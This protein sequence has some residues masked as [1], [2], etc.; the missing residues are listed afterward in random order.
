MS[1]GSS[2]IAN[3][4]QEIC[5]NVS[6]WNSHIKHFK[7]TP[8]VAKVFMNVLKTVCHFFAKTHCSMLSTGLSWDYFFYTLVLHWRS[9]DCLPCVTFPIGRYCKKLLKD[10]KKLI[11]HLPPFCKNTWSIFPIKISI[12]SFKLTANHT[13]AN[14]CI[15]SL[16][17]NPDILKNPKNCHGLW[18][19]STFQLMLSHYYR[20]EFVWWCPNRKFHARSDEISWKNYF[21]PCIGVLI[22]RKF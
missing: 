15:C 22:V 10:L 8:K 14:F 18:F 6:F 16:H 4:C 19:R 5:W 3:F 1:P 20:F 21:E 12:E 17:Q 7:Q 13:N 9:C 2:K 11:F